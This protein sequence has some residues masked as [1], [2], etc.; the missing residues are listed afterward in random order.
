[1]QLRLWAKRVDD[2]LEMTEVGKLVPRALEEQHGDV[3]LS[4][5][6]GA[7]GGRLVVGVQGKA[8]EG[9]P[10]YARQRRLGLR[11]R[12]HAPAEGFSA[13]D[14]RRAGAQPRRLLDRRANGGVRDSRPVGTALALLR[15]RKIEGKRHNPQTRKPRRNLVH[16]RMP[17]IRTGA[18]RQDVIGTR[19]V[20]LYHD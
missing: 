19:N 7:F 6:L 12:R 9:E 13:G 17:H 2:G 15:V 18:I 5:V 8:K 1:M 11:L 20:R 14:E 16:E 3:D 10:F 4:E